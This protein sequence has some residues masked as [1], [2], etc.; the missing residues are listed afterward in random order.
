MPAIPVV[1]GTPTAQTQ[2]SL[3]IC[4]ALMGSTGVDTYYLGR[5]LDEQPDGG[6]LGIANSFGN[7]NLRE[8]QA[9]TFT[10]GTVMDFHDNFTLT[11]DWYEIE[12]ENM[13]ALAGADSTY[14]KCLDT[15]FNPTGNPNTPECEL[16]FRDPSSG[17]AAQI[18]RTFNNEGRA[19]MSGIDLQLNWSRP[20]GA[21]GFNMNTVANYNLEA[22]TQ[23]SAGVD[24]VDH[25]GFNT[26]GLQI[27]CQ[28]YDYRLFSTF[29]YFRGA[30]NVSLRHQHWP[31]LDSGA[32]RT[33]TSSNG[34]INGSLPSY[35]LFALTAGYTFADR[36]RVSVGVE[37]L[38]DEEP[39]CTGANPNAP[40]FPTDCTHQGGSTYDP[41]GRNYYVSMTMDF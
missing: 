19:L 26:C 2:Q 1:P 36:Y 6:G 30:W 37:N 27:Q 16:I 24:E 8:E 29:S 13:V 31:A 38:L 15:S 14:Q 17:G 28:R 7:P 32:C 9:D 11:V 4:Q 5:P 23:D 33:N 10:L 41:L 22:I 3:A 25:A 40:N 34:C 20:L 18:E 35:N 39:P 21:G 12:I